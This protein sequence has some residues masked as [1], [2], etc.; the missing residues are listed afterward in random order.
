MKI[1]ILLVFSILAF[2]FQLSAFSAEI[3]SSRRLI[4]QADL[5]DGE[6][7][8]YRGEAVAAIIKRAG[9]SWINVNDG[10]SA[11]GV[12]CHNKAADTVKFLGDS[13]HKGDTLEVRG[14]FHRACPEHG[15]ELDIHADEVIVTAEGHRVPGRLDVEKLKISVALFLIT[16]VLAFMFRKKL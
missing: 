13:K 8:M 15:G 16:I 7:V 1:K 6:E 12:W 14:I 3:A 2:N 11:I 4:E 5:L 9:Y 10:S